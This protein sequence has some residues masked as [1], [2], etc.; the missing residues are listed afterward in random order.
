M[1]LSPIPLRLPNNPLI[2]LSQAKPSHPGYGG[3][4]EMSCGATVAISDILSTLKK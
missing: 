4:D 3:A 1:S 2:D